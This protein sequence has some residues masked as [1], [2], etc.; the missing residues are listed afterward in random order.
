MR[1]GGHCVRPFNSVRARLPHVVVVPL[2]HGVAVV[3]AVLLRLI[4][5]LRRRLRALRQGRGD[6][7]HHKD[8]GSNN[9]LHFFS[10]TGPMILRGDIL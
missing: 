5:P 7:R 9:R 8:R 10:P 3:I 1:R 2:L 4:A 6:D